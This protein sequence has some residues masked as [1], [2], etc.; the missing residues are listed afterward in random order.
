[1][2]RETTILLIQLAAFYAFPAW[3]EPVSPI[4]MV[5]LI[6]YATF[7]LSVL[8]GGLS[9]RKAK[10]L[11]P[12][13]ISALFV[14]SVFVYYNES[15]LIHSVWYLAVSGAGVL[16]GGIVRTLLYKVRQRQG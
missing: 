16:I 11:Y 5:L 4:G 6:L 10:Y 2:K 15:A 7:I 13:L 1:M 3:A 8:M 9:G 14:P 12:A